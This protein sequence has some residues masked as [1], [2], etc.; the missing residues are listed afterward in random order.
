LP[1]RIGGTIVVTHYYH[2]VTGV[3][4]MVDVADEFVGGWKLSSPQ[5]GHL[6][7]SGNVQ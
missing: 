7:G 2:P 3:N 5:K 6:L 4:V 1:G